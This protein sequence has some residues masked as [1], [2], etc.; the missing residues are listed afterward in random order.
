[1]SMQDVV[2][3]SGASRASDV[4]RRAH[5]CLERGDLQ[6]ADDLCRVA[7][8]HS[9]DDFELLMIR[10]VVEARQG[11][12]LAAQQTVERVLEL[13]PGDPGAIRQRTRIAELQSESRK[14]P[15]TQSFLSKRA[16][17]LN[18]PRTISIETIGKCNATCNFCPAP[19]LARNDKKMS[20]ELFSKIV[21]DIQEIPPEAP[22][23]IN[24]NLVNEPFMDKKMFA[25]LR[26][27][28]E[29]LPTAR[30]QIYT[31]FNVLPRD[32]MAKFRQIRNIGSLN[33][34]FNAA[35]EADYQAIMHIDFARTVHHL[36]TFMKD[37]RRDRFLLRP[38]I[39]SRV[40]DNTVRDQEYVEECRALFSEFEEG[41]D[42]APYV[43]KRVTWL[44]DTHVEQSPV[45]YF[46]PCDAWFDL[47]IMCTGVVPL[48]CLDA[49]GDH[50]IGDVTRNSVLEIYNS[51]RFRELR[52]KHLQRES[53][54]PCG[55]CSP[56]AAT[57]EDP[58]HF[59][60]RTIN[61]D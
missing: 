57:R 25:R 49:E 3:Q 2:V 10:A 4:V 31:N 23:N 5:Q 21:R 7:L 12:Y 35:N 30:I 28:N 40:A 14:H 33:I 46:L 55:Q 36:K 45:P 19:E 48:C 41:I 16:V 26:Y 22:I 27:I 17:Y 6:G 15:Y 60:F 43:K 59:T 9:P 61:D 29:A 44:G 39:L 47:N 53:L 56:Y 38:V 11:R 13:R 58:N 34:S 42:Y 37:N 50:A 18:F 52:E 51:P 1:M 32:F 54:H 20:D 8:G 24:M